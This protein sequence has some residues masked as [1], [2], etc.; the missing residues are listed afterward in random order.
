MVNAP[1]VSFDAPEAYVGSDYTL[2]FT[3]DA[4]FGVQ[5][6]TVKLGEE[7]VTA[8]E[9]DGTYTVVIPQ[10]KVAGD[11]L[12]VTVSGKDTKG[13]AISG[14]VEITVKDEPVITDVTP[15][16]GSE[17]GDTKKPEISAV[18]VN[19]GE[20]PKVEMKVNDKAD[21]G[22]ELSTYSVQIDG[23]TEKAKVY[24][25]WDTFKMPAGNV[26]ITPVFEAKD[27]KL[28]IDVDDS[29]R[30]S[31]TVK[32]GDA[33]ATNLGST[34]IPLT[35]K[36]GEKVVFTYTA[37]SGYLIVDSTGTNKV[38]IADNNTKVVTI[39]MPA[40]DASITIK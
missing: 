28:T 23:S 29:I 11:K 40:G 1:V 20:N 6:L 17:T 34:P 33:E 5:E 30:S 9:A 31:I 25:S 16:T 27:N 35:V 13:V 38:T 24:N 22:Y 4:V 10:E 26:T 3:V 36:S 7:T 15:K 21:E 14:S 12:G 19:A 39:T 18:I 8:T 37:D 2:T 32:I